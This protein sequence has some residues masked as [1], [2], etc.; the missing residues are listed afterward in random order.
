[1]KYPDEGYIKYDINWAKAPAHK[2]QHID[3]LIYWRELVVRY[4]GIGYDRLMK[5]GVGN[6]STR[7]EAG[8]YIS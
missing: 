7:Y 3:E 1:M 4:G 8:F 6:I 5:V 2:N